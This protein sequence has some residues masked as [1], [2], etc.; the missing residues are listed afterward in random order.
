LADHEDLPGSKRGH[1]RWSRE[2]NGCRRGLE[3]G[4]LADHE[5]SARYRGPRGVMTGVQESS[6][7]I[8]RND[9]LGIVGNDSEECIRDDSSGRYEVYVVSPQLREG[10]GVALIDTG[11][12]I[13]LVKESSLIRFS[14]E[15]NENF[16]I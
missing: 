15:K 10:L 7:G 4:S 3:D 5:D 2:F 12:Q 8:T 1:D 16:K 9:R 11:S 6:P 13:S 14:K